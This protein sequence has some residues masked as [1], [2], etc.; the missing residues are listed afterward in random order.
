MPRGLQID[1]R[2]IGQRRVVVAV[3]RRRVRILEPVQLAGQ[4]QQVRRNPAV[5]GVGV[6]DLAAGFVLGLRRDDLVLGQIGWQAP[7]RT[8]A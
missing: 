4:R 1:D 2:V 3:D 6:A 8:R 5:G 7:R